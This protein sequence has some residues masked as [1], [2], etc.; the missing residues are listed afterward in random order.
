[1]RNPPAAKRA[2]ARRQSGGRE[3]AEAEGD[4]LRRPRRARDPD[5]HPRPKLLDA[6]GGSD[7]TPVAAV[8]APVVPGPRAMGTRAHSASSRRPAPIRSR[9]VRSPTTTAGRV[10]SPD[11]VAPTIRSPGRLPRVVHRRRLPPRRTPS[12]LLSPGRSSWARPPRVR[13]P[14]EAGSSCSPRSRP[15]SAGPMLSDSRRASNASGFGS[16]AVL[17]SST[18]KPLRAGYYVVYTGPFASLA[19]V[20]RSAAHVHAFGYRTAYVREIL[21]Y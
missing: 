20:Q 7:P 12:Q 13:S 5:V 18:R 8:C 14:N 4:C 17:D 21:R 10:R 16:L 6:L 1:M 19:A 2:E 11:R 9:P 15:A 3:G